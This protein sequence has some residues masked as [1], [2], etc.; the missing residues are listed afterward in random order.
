M[1]RTLVSLL[2]ILLM[3]VFFVIMAPVAAF[4]FAAALVRLGF[5]IGYSSLEKLL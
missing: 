2:R 5:H 1:T 3:L 4:G